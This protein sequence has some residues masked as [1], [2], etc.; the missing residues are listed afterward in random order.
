LNN[1]KYRAGHS[2]LSR[3]IRSCHRLDD[4]NAASIRGSRVS[5]VLAARTS[6]RSTDEQPEAGGCD[7]LITSCDLH[8]VMAYARRIPRARRQGLQ[9]AVIRC[10]PCA[11]AVALA[12]GCVSLRQPTPS[13]SEVLLIPIAAATAARIA[14]VSAST[15]MPASR[16]VIPAAAVVDRVLRLDVVLRDRPIQAIEFAQESTALRS[17][18]VTFGTTHDPAAV[19]R[20]FA[21]DTAGRSVAA[22]ALANAARGSGLV[23]IAPV[24]LNPGDAAALLETCATFAASLRRSG[25]RNVAVLVPASDTAAYPTKALSGVADVLVLRTEPAV[26]P[27][28]PGPPLA[29]QEIRRI[30]GLRGS[31]IGVSRLSLL[32]PAHGYVWRTGSIP[33]A[34]THAAAAV[35]A[36]SWRVPLVRDP[37]SGTLYARAPGE[38]EIWIAD[39][40]SVL[41]LMRAARVMGI[42]RFAFIAGAGEDPR[43]W[44]ALAQT[45]QTISSSR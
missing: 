18:L 11:I 16:P 5:R 40:E 31:Q 4:G 22:A 10:S 39:A 8:R 37:A 42:R 34:I 35:L 32:I 21:A 33:R 24:G 27:A 14:P 36:E 13:P 38:G 17:A 20:V 6:G 26:P 9:A 7:D 12:T 25:I 3:D 28:V 45:P 41:A 23:V 43:L 19:L 15:E 44:D 29:V 1:A 30:I 2:D